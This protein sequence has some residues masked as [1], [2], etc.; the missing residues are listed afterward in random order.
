MIL[1]NR[2]NA[3]KSKDFKFCPNNTKYKRTKDLQRMTKINDFKKPA[4]PVQN[5]SFQ[6]ALK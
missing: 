1:K 2:Q 5:Q 3:T 6:N 4:K